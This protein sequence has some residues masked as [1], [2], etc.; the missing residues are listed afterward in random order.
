MKNFIFVNMFFFLTALSSNAL[1][2][3]LV[4]EGDFPDQYVG[5]NTNSSGYEHGAIVIDQSTGMIQSIETSS[6]KIE[7]LRRRQD[8]TFVYLKNQATGDFDVIYPGLIDLHNHTKQNNLGIWKQAHGQFANRFEWRAWGDYTKSVSNNMNPW[9]GYGSPVTCAAF[10]WSELQ[11][12][13]IGT[14]YLQGP[15]YCVDNFAIHQ[16]EGS[17]AFP[18]SKKENVQAPTD[19]VIPNDMV[20]VWK[21]LKPLIDSGQ[22]YEQALAQV[23]NEYCFPDKLLGRAFSA[24][25]TVSDEGLD[26]LTDKD[27]LEAAC[28]KKVSLEELPEKFIRYVYWVHKSIASKKD[29]ADK[30]ASGQGSAIIAHLSEGR[31]DDPYNQKEYEVVK[32]LGMNKKGVNFV[33]GVGISEADLADMSANQMGIIWSPFS[34]LLLY[35]QT[36]D[37]ELALK[38]GVML[39]LG[40][41]WLPT[42]SKGPLEELKV[43]LE[44]LRKTGADKAVAK[45]QGAE[46]SLYRALYMMVTENPAK[47]INHWQ[48]TGSDKWENGEAE[49]GVGTLAPH[50]MGSLIVA[51]KMDPQDPYK[52]LVA[53]VWENDINLVVVDGYIQYGNETYVKVA[54]SDY[55][56]MSLNNEFGMV[57]LLDDKDAPILFERNE[58]PSKDEELV[59]LEE[60][61]EY[62]SGKASQGRVDALLSCEFSDKKVF[63]HQNTLEEEDDLQLFKA[64]SGMN[65]DRY[66]DIQRLLGVNITTQSRNLNDPERGDLNFA[67]GGD[68]EVASEDFTPLYTCNDSYHSQRIKNFI[69]ETWPRDKENRPA[70]FS[71]KPAKMAEDYK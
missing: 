59:F 45:M 27:K 67:I 64:A 28:T 20:F 11:A 3:F 70:T 35:N 24:A 50:A 9:I 29:Y 31:R 10:R 48:G 26:V 19:L 60:L 40:S 57:Q 34:N 22:T 46:S 69:S 14:T 36:L 39:A 12:M 56:P 66:Q 7:V 65:L 58:N 47:M 32:L 8:V 4:L 30:I 17:G 5:Q 13:V 49:G 55:E 6:E 41:D 23:I 44:Y 62:I 37:V 54:T 33:H 63:V 68:P 52:N 25:D 53:E 71:N 61:S 42:G 1:A 2:S 21:T 38:K 43:A 51:S 16:V 15:S 18:R